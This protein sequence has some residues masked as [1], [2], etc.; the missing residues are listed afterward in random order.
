MNIVCF[1]GDLKT[2][3]FP[4]EIIFTFNE[5]I[6]QK[7]LVSIAYSIVRNKRRPYVY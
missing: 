4:S 6:G 7:I 5:Y 3:K 1:L 2:P